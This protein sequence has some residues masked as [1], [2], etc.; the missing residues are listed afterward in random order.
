[1]NVRN[2]CTI[3]TESR[4]LRYYFNIRDREGLIPDEE[5]SDLPDIGAAMREARASARDFVADDL[6]A[7]R[8]IHGRSIEIANAQGDVLDVFSVHDLLN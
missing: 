5:G 2:R 7:D 6:K 3:R 1:M 8:P 4:T